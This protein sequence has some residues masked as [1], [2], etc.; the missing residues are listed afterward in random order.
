M[1][2]ISVSAPD[3]D[4]ELEAERTH[5]SESRAALRRMRGRA[6]ALFSA[7][8]DVAGDAYSAETLGRTLSRRIVEL[9][10][11]PS[12]PLFFGRLDIGDADYHI[13]R[14]HVTDDVG[15]PL[16]LDWRA[17]LSRRFYRASVRDPQGVATRRRFGFVKGDL[18]SFEDEH[19]DRGEEPDP[20][21]GDRTP[22]GR[23]DA[24]H[25][26]DHPAGAGRA[27]PRRPGG[28]DLRAGRAR[29]R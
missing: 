28:L 10:D 19:L 26:R 9:A 27:G 8:D 11:D 2:K 14:R 25:R 23:A 5:L 18:T 3:L 16:V 24:G 22:A 13:G 12:T 4:T 17:P 7:G 20:D 1:G 29:H 15:E 6:E 21:R